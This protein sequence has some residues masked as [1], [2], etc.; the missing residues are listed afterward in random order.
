MLDIEIN[1]ARNLFTLKSRG[2]LSEEDFARLRSDVDGYIDQRH[3]APNILIVTEEGFPYWDSLN[4][5]IAHAKFVRDHHRLVKKIAIVGDSFVLSVAP[6]IADHFVAASVKH[7][8]SEQL[9]EARNW[10]TTSDSSSDE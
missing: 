1:S 6:S 9:G 7:F 3:A 8:P 2:P 4:T 10:L 5:M